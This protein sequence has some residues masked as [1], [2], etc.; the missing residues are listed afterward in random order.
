MKKNLLI[1]VFL[2]FVTLSS[3][4]VVVCE[5]TLPI[6]ITDLGVYTKSPSI[7]SVGFHCISDDGSKVA[8]IAYLDYY[9]SSDE[10]TELDYNSAEIFVINS[11]GSNLKQI[12]N[13]T[14]QGILP[15]L[16]CS[17]S[18]DGSKIVFYGWKDYNSPN[19]QSGIFTINSDGSELKQLTNLTSYGR[20]S[21]SDDGSK[22]AFFT[23]S[24][25]ATD[26]FVVNSD[27]TGLKQL[28]SNTL[29]V[30]SFQISG[31]G[32]K[33]VF[34]QYPSMSPDESDLFVVNSD[35]TELKQLTSG[36]SCEVSPSI[37][38]DGSK[39]AF[40]SILDYVDELFVINSDGSGL[41]QLTDKKF[42]F[43]TA[44]SSISGDGTKIVV[45]SAIDNGSEHGLFVVN[46]DGSEWH[47]LDPNK[48]GW[49]IGIGP[50]S[51]SRDGSKIVIVVQ[52][53]NDL[54]RIFVVDSDVSSTEP[55]P[56]IEYLVVIILA[57]VAISVLIVFVLRRK[58]LHAI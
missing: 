13:S 21:I 12:T 40:V 27:G 18:G 2:S 56:V 45:R 46:S 50:W 20:P 1:V 29:D 30:S 42:A 34:L 22:V 44:Y 58:K 26:L 6:K 9:S 53:N 5:N 48:V 55:D 25:G 43:G 3:V 39:I 19:P 33:I 28:T 23:K 8:F 10:F 17:I 7:K 36:S 51:L 49:P 54:P 4:A 47:Q 38:D 14:A 41:Q 24:N 16:G 57:V 52:E 15:K 32:S 37:S 11:D 31:D 35:G